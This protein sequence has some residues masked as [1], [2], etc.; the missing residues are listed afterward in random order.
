MHD[1]RAWRSGRGRVP[2]GT[3]RPKPLVPDRLLRGH[4]ACRTRLSQRLTHLIQLAPTVLHVGDTLELR[5]RA[6]TRGREAAA[7]GGEKR[8]DPVQ[9]E[10]GA[11]GDERDAARAEAEVVEGDDPVAHEVADVS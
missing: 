1:P 7:D 5:Q 10:P 3:G 9:P 4:V 6:G 11:V 2:R 8:F